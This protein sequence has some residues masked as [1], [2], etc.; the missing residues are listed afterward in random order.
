MVRSLLVLSGKA[1]VPSE[2][3]SFVLAVDILGRGVSPECEDLI[4]ILDHL[5]N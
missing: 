3:E 4:V 5:C 2:N 1:G